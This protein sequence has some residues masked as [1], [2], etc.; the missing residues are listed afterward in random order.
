MLNRPRFTR[1]FIAAVK[2]IPEK[3]YPIVEVAAGHAARSK[4]PE[5]LN[6]SAQLFHAIWATRQACIPAG[7]QARK[8]AGYSGHDLLLQH[9]SA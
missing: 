2:Q 1:H 8:H 4:H 5:K 9:P 3:R 7:M 6:L